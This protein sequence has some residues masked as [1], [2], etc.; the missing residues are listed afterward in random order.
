MGNTE[1]RPINNIYHN[2]HDDLEINGITTIDFT[3]EPNTLGSISIRHE[4][5]IVLI[6]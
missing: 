1:L 5:L 3:L 2:E 6:D 4:Q